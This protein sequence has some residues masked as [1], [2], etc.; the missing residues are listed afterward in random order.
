M[1][2][3]QYFLLIILIFS[4]SNCILYLEEDFQEIEF[5]TPTKFSININ[6]TAFFKYKLEEQKELIGLKFLRS[7]L[8]TV[9][10]TIYSSYED[11]KQLITYSMAQNQFK[12]IN[13][14]NCND[15]VYIII[16]ETNVNYHYD[17]YLT[18]YDSKRQLKLEHN[19][20]I[21]INN[22][23]SNNKYELIYPS[24]NKSIIL[25][26]NTQNFE[27]NKRTLSIKYENNT[28]IDK[29]E[30]SEYKQFFNLTGNDNLIVTIENIIE[31][32]EDIE[33]ENQEFSIIIYEVNQSDNNFNQILKNQIEIINYI[34]N[35]ESQIYYFYTDISSFHN[36]NTFNF[37]LNFDYNIIN[38]I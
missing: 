14:T 29:Y 9:R 30:T 27:K 22:F 28:I 1:K 3:I 12:E 37:K 5:M 8:Y 10:V 16:E 34:Y 7:N 6:K 25:L 38:L 20:V 36:S 15:Y 24:S 33:L 26:Y 18:I 11:K 21:S 17:D 35:N 4:F 32:N 31:K 13:V 2:S 19:K 23:L